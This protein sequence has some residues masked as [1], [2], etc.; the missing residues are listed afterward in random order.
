MYVLSALLPLAKHA[1]DLHFDD[2]ET[3][4]LGSYSGVN[5]LQTAVHE[6][7]HCLGLDHSKVRGCIMVASYEGYLPDLQLHE[8][9]IRGVQALYGPPLVKK[10][11][12]SARQIWRICPGCVI[13]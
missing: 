8:D 5:L 7:G 10:T 1:G 2:D 9:D 3:W 13:M 11:Q 4:T 6:L 12:D